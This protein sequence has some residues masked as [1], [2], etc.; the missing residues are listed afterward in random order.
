MYDKTRVR[1]DYHNMSYD[2]FLAL[3]IAVAIGIDTHPVQFDYTKPT[4]P[5][6]TKAEFQA[7]IDSFTGTHSEYKQGGRS[8]KPAAEKAYKIMLFGMDKVADYVDEIADGDEGTIIISGFEVAYGSEPGQ[9]PAAPGTPIVKAARAEAAGEID[10]ECDVFGR[11]AKYTC[12][13]SEEK[14]LHADTTNSPDGKLFIPP[15]NT[16]RIFFMMDIHRKKKITGLKRGVDYWIYFIV[17]NTAGTSPI[18]DGFMI[19]CA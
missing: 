10:V 14:P 7:F 1:R 12:I 6:Y 13:I 19:M 15:G 9:K 17:S 2:L 4:K 8:Q 18:S 3:C 11:D 5:P 16:N